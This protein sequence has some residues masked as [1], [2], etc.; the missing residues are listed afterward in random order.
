MPTKKKT[1]KKPAKK[2]L[3]K[4]TQTKNI[5]NEEVDKVLGYKKM[6]G[7]TCITF[8]I[9]HALLIVQG[10]ILSVVDAIVLIPL[11]VLYLGDYKK[12]FNYFTI[13]YSGLNLLMIIF[14]LFKTGG[15]GLGS[16]IFYIIL[17]TGSI[18][19]LKLEGEQKRGK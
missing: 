3:K 12:I 13:G 11:G 9:V 4:A 16:L 2:V 18:N 17:L 15:F 19:L 6:L 14:L 10:H 5:E 7:I 1:E 8:G